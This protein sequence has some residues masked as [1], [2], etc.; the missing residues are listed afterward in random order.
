M[1]KF[2]LDAIDVQLPA[3]LS[4]ISF[5]PILTD[6]NN[7]TWNNQLSNNLPGYLMIKKFA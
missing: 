5:I 4:G 1:I 6:G 2:S 3:N 7:L